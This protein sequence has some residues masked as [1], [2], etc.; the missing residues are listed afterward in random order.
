MPALEQCH[1]IS[2][3]EDYAVIPDIVDQ[4]TNHSKFLFHQMQLYDDLFAYFDFVHAME[5]I[6][7]FQDDNY[8]ER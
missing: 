5:S 4:S 8:R 3:I 2:D 6:Y 1:G 7:N